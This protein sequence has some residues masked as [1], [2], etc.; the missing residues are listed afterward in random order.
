MP[1]DQSFIDRASAIKHQAR[2]DR[3]YFDVAEEYGIEF[4]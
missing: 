4:G 1:N 3:W 2:A